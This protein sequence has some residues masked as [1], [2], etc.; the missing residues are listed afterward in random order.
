[1]SGRFLS[2]L[3]FIGSFLALSPDFDNTAT[4]FGVERINGIASA[5]FD[6]LKKIISSTASVHRCWISIV[7]YSKLSRGEY[8]SVLTFLFHPHQPF[9]GDFTVAFIIPD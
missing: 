5:Q 6:F 7:C 4:A 9:C 1:M 2:L 8:L 3:L